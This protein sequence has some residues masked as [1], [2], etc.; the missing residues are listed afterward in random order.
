MRE[1]HGT[2]AARVRASARQVFELITDVDRLP[3]WNRAIERSVERPAA[4]TPD[5]E[6]V[7]VMHP[8]GMPSWKSRSHPQEIEP[9]TRFAYRSHSD[10]SNP[11]YALLRWDIA[12]TLDS[13]QV[14]VSWDGYSKTIGR[15]LI[16]APIRRRMLERE[17]AASLDTIRR[18]LE[19]AGAEAP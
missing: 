16:A 1:F 4:L 7:V 8:P 11:S 14:T 13:V 2:A 6:W 19:P 15:K 10:D 9:G 17:V 12:P 5:A 3:E 18:T